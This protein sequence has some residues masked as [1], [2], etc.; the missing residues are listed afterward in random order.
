MGIEKIC[1]EE[2]KLMKEDITIIPNTKEAKKQNGMNYQGYDVYVKPQ[3]LIDLVN[4]KCLAINI[5]GEYVV[6]IHI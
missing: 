1:K 4:N 5:D 3:D 2:I 6:F